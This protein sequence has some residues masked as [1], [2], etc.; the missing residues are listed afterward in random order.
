VRPGAAAA[1]DRSR[2]APAFAWQDFS[3]FVE[4]SPVRTG[5]LV[6]WGRYEDQGRRRLVLGNRIYPELAGVRRRLANEA[7]ALTGRPHL[8]EEALELFDRNARLAG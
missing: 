3:R 6:V 5:W 4:V 8:A 1:N 2:D 7:L